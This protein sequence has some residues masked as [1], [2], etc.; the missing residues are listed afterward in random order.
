MDGLLVDK[1]VSIVNNGPGTSLVL[2]DH[3]DGADVKIG[4]FLDQHIWKNHPL[5][6]HGHSVTISWSRKSLCSM[7]D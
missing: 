1:V 5:P 3:T 6:M 2:W 4:D 7:A